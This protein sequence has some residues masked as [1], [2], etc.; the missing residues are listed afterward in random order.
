[1]KPEAERVLR[2]L[3]AAWVRIRKAGRENDPAVLALVERAEC[4]L[5]E[6]STPRK[7]S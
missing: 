5:R 1:M 3:I 2:D 4:E 7:L 6:I